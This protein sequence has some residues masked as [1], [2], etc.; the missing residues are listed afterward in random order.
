VRTIT[1]SK[2]G[3]NKIRGQQFE[4]KTTDFEDSIKSFSPGEWVLLKL[5]PEEFWF[6][7]I[8][9]LINDKFICGYVLGVY[10][11]EDEK[12]FSEQNFL[13]MVITKAQSK[14]QRFYGYEKA[15]RLFYGSADGLPGLIIDQFDNM[16]IIQINTAGIDR[17]REFIKE[18][19]TELSGVPSYLL[20]NAKY[21]E[22]ELLPVYANDML[23]DL[24]VTENEIKFKIRS[25]VIQKIGFYYDH[26]ENRH[27][28]M[29]LIS[30]LKVIPV[31]AVDLFCYSGAWGLSALKAGVQ[32]CDFVDQGDFA[33]E[34]TEALKLNDLER[35][36]RFHRGD[37]FKFLDESIVKKNSYDMILCDPPAFAKNPSQKNQA[38]DGYSKLHRKVFKILKL[39]GIVAFSSCTHYVNHQEFQKNIL[40][41]ALK[42]G[43]RIQLIYAGIQGF[44]HPVYSQD[45]RSNYIKSYFYI[46][47]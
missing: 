21:R 12:K 14:R 4:L 24:S 47:E 18:V 40:E 5:S 42:E 32:S 11:K 8:N 7:F 34:I 37:V 27:Q 6:G 10:R 41:S 22:K 30:R 43:R 31:K 36:G 33:N 17:H 23:P 39:G 45:D 9:P 26:R 1:L 25:E 3:T 20:D 19:A 28:L 35:K 44:D 2:S 29:N 38:L 16:S 13:K 46:A 15:S